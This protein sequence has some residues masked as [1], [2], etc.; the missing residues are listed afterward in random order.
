MKKVHYVYK[1]IYVK[2]LS[3]YKKKSYLKDH[4]NK[5]NH[6]ENIEKN[7]KCAVVNCN[8]SFNSFSDLLIHDTIHYNC[9]K[10]K[11]YRIYNVIKKYYNKICSKKYEN[12]IF[13]INLNNKEQNKIEKILINYFQNNMLYIYVDKVF[14]CNI[15]G[16]QKIFNSKLVYK[17]HIK[18]YIHSLDK[19]ISSLDDNIENFDLKINENIIFTIKNV[20]HWLFT[21]KDWIQ[22]INFKNDLNNSKIEKDSYILNCNNKHNEFLYIKNVIYKNK[23]TD[24][25]SEFF[26]ECFGFYNIK[27]CIT[28]ACKVYDMSFIVVGTK[29]NFNNINYANSDDTKGKLYTFTVNLKLVDI[30]SIDIGFILKIMTSPDTNSSLFCL[31]SDGKIRKYVYNNKYSCVFCYNTL[32]CIDFLVIENEIIYWT[33][34]LQIFKMI[35]GENK[36]KSG[37]FDSFVNS[38]IFRKRILK[39][40]L[41]HDSCNEI[42][43]ESDQNYNLNVN[44]NFFNVLKNKIKSY[45]IICNTVNGNIFA[46]DK[47]LKD[48][49]SL[50]KNFY[51]HNVI[52]S[53]ITDSIFFT[54]QLYNTTKILFIENTYVKTK[55]VVQI[56][57]YSCFEDKEGIYLGGYSGTV[58]RLKYRNKKYK[59]T[60]NVRFI[61]KENDIFVLDDEI[62]SNIN[63]LE[64]CII[65]LLKFDYYLFIFLKCGLIFKVY[66]N[67]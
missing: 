47:D 7:Y 17:M 40:N 66:V 53:E 45:F 33:D 46:L 13:L 65:D 28:C 31:S 23:C 10:D 64:C 27:E 32:N 48:R 41:H 61:K 18:T 6:F 4:L 43:N 9:N 50:M 51:T 37:Y 34:G 25:I 8:C 3:Y 44:N 14:K 54:N 55:F 60:F 2:C 30:I 57:F 59:N 38:L 19:L 52:Y 67:N 15:P 56:P 63:N 36:N 29:M 22:C 62:E 1:C 16:C 11:S 26:N 39:N 12:E 20:S 42:Y 49:I 35:K 5:I 21:E 58:Q 24:K